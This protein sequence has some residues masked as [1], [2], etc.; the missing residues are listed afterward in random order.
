MEIFESIKNTISSTA[1]TAAKKS[2]ELVEI[3]KLKMAISNLEADIARLMRDIGEIVYEG[4]KSGEADASEELP[5]ICK[6]I[7]A[8]YEDIEASKAK[9]R[10]LKNLKLC[11]SC[12]T[13]SDPDAVFCPKCGQK[14]Q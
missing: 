14:F 10:K 12:M 11:N 8:K 4:Y 9:L 7:E 5:E 6:Q 2:N 13:E 1:K 3:T